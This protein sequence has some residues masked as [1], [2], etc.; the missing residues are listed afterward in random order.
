MD[1]LKLHVTIPSVPPLLR[2]RFSTVSPFAKCTSFRCDQAAWQAIETA[3]WHLNMSTGSF[4]RL[5]AQAV[6]EAVITHVNE[7]EEVVG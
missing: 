4:L 1:T 5:S 3:A 7:K 2:G 6:A